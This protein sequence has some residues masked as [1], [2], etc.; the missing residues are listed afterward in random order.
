[1]SIYSKTELVLVFAISLFTACGGASKTEE[2]SENEPAKA[3]ES[4]VSQSENIQPCML[5]TQSDIESALGWSDVPEGTADSFVV[6]GVQT[7]TTCEYEWEDRVIYFSV[8]DRYTAEAGMEMFEAGIAVLEKDTTDKDTFERVSGIG[9][10]AAWLE[11]RRYFVF[12]VGSR[13]YDF[14][15]DLY[16]S[17]GKPSMEAAKALAQ[18]IIAKL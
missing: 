9:D 11:K 14:T 4:E 10:G 5:L 1:M 12:V 6:E 13:V 15:L 3:E 16:Q 8:T 17:E 7:Q 18:K 2:T